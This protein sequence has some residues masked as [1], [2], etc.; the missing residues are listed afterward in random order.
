MMWSQL[1]Y[2][3]LQMKQHKETALVNFGTGALEEI[4]LLVI[5]G[6]PISHQHK[7]PDGVLLH[8]MISY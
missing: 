2:H 6:L 7:M 5:S 1:M 8:N 4:L 3:A